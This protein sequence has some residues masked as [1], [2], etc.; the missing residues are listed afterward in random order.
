[1]RIEVV[2]QAADAAAGAFFRAHYPDLYRYVSASTGLP[3]ADVDDLVQETLVQAWRDRGRFGSAGAP[4]PWLLGIARNR[5]RDLLRR[6]RVRRDAD[7]ILRALGRMQIEEV[8]PDLLE[9]AELGARVREA[10]QQLPQDYSELL[11]LRY[12]EEKPLKAIAE[13]NSE[14]EDAVESRLRRAREAFRKLLG[15]GA[16]HDE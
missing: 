3:G 4:L 8:A 1:V 12:L 6:R 16:G 13:L 11:L 2:D 14:T 5:V 10:L 15:E 7:R 9:S